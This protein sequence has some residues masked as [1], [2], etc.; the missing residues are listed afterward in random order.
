MFVENLRTKY[1]PKKPDPDP[2]LTFVGPSCGTLCNTLLELLVY[3]K[4]WSTLK[5]RRNKTYQPM[6]Y[7][8]D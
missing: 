5:R 3:L 2:E 6:Q 8:Q 4:T 7:K 1:I